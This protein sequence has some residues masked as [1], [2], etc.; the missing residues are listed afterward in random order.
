MGVDKRNIFLHGMTESMPYISRSTPFERK[1]PSRD[2]P[3]SHATYITRR[4]QE[5]REQSLT[6][7]QVAAIR[8]K[9]GVYLEFSGA[10]QHDLAIKS[11]ENRQK[12]IRLLNVKM[13]EKSDTIKATV[14]IPAGQ[15]T[16][17]IDKVQAY[18]Q[19]ITAGKK[20]ANN[21][22]VR[23]IEN[24]KLAIL[25]SFWVG[26]LSEMPGHTPAWGEIWLRY[27]PENLEVSERDFIR[28]CSDL[29]IEL[30]ENHIVFPERVVRLIRAHNEQLKTR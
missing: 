5:C 7:K 17:F 16:Y 11:L 6:Q 26:D 23:S 15:E 20:P 25:D 12:G 18:S 28:C 3:F 24:V 27:D 29:A 19:P 14:Y 1:F 30:N 21:D 4:L 13:D 10:A 22:L 8:Y 9:E 2:N